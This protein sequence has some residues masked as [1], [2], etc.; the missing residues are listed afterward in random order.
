MLSPDVI[1][2]VLPHYTYVELRR[3]LQ[4]V[5]EKSVQFANAELGLGV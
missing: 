2:E 5:S 3:E 4:G 1:H